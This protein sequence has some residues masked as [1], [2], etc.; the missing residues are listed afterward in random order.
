MKRATLYKTILTLQDLEILST[1]AKGGGQFFIILQTTTETS[2]DFK[3]CSRQTKKN[4]K[5]WSIIW[6]ISSEVRALHLVVVFD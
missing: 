6:T 5:N 1:E 2:W 3:A 4:T